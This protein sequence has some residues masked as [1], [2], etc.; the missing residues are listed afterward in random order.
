[1]ITENDRVQDTVDALSAGDLERV[2]ELLNASHASLRDCFEISTPGVERT[3]DRLRD[4][5]A[6]GARIMGGGFGG[7]VLGLLAPG[8]S[9]PDGA[10][11]VQP[12]PGARIIR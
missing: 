9:A 8:V 3:V 7:Y 6:I 2:G 1:V 11:E 4:A 10:L 12:G 5:G